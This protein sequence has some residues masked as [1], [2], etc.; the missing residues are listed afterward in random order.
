MSQL[1]SVDLCEVLYMCMYIFIYFVKKLKR[2][3]KKIDCFGL[4]TGHSETPVYFRK[5]LDL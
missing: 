4:Y 3:S 1:N 2:K 5:C